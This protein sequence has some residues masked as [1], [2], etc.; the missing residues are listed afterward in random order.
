MLNKLN[1]R[2]T[3]KRK[4]KVTQPYSQLTSNCPQHK[5]RDEKEGQ[6]PGGDPTS[7]P[8]NGSVFPVSISLPLWHLPE[9]VSRRW[10]KDWA[11]K[12]S[13]LT[14]PVNDSISPCLHPPHLPTCPFLPQ[15][16]PGAPC[17]LHPALPAPKP[18]SVP[19]HKATAFWIPA[20]HHSW[21]MPSHPGSATSSQLLNASCCT[22]GQ[23]FHTHCPH[24]LCEHE[25]PLTPFSDQGW[26]IP[27]MS[28]LCS[29]HSQWAAALAD[30]G[31]DLR[32]LGDKQRSLQWTTAARAGCVF[33]T[34]S[35]LLST[36]SVNEIISNKWVLHKAVEQA[37]CLCLAQPLG[38]SQNNVHMLLGQ[39][40]AFILRDALGSG[41]SPPAHH[42][43]YSG[44]LDHKRPF[45]FLR[46]GLRRALY[47]KPNDLNYSLSILT[48]RKGLQAFY[49]L[50]STK[51]LGPD[52][53]PISRLCQAG[54]HQTDPAELQER[55][56]DLGK[57]HVWE[58]WQDF[59]D[60]PAETS[61]FFPLRQLF[62][63]FH[64][65]KN[66]SEMLQHILIHGA[67]AA[68]CGILPFSN[69][70][71]KKFNGIDNYLP[72]TGWT[73]KNF[74]SPK[75]NF[76]KFKYQQLLWL[77]CCCCQFQSAHSSTWQWNGFPV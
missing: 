69:L 45:G 16:C 23:M 43:Y 57:G 36:P 53:E 14:D 37:S 46:L 11:R 50:L 28:S 56:D 49:F 35:I 40:P 48:I 1:G 24:H 4:N 42:I 64:I 3:F 17:T 8:I 12:C 44:L 75:K 27:I 38:S 52:F 26:A 2:E 74:Q 5:N 67:V 18:L 76:K 58:K 66:H 15:N 20:K 63:H 25:R 55:Q 41:Q 39:G 51:Q 60:K 22:S 19:S 68:V 70:S 47:T 10:V 13:C 62:Y 9:E 7:G 30:F 34:S 61:V 29:F 33:K 73:G 65:L 32:D 31:E 77:M 6:A 21:D 59:L 54:A 72:V 71:G